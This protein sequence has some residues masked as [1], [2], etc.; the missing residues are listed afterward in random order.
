MCSI[1][2]NYSLTILFLFKDGKK[3]V[4]VVGDDDDNVQN[5][6]KAILEKTD[7]GGDRAARG[8]IINLI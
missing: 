4:E 1:Q 6:Y 7:G 8:K 5:C 3:E 2:L